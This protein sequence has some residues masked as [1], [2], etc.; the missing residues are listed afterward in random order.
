M[1]FCMNCDNEATHKYSNENG[2]FPLCFTCKE[3][4]GLGQ[5]NQDAEIKMINE[6][7]ED[8]DDSN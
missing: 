1:I 2:T 5:V 6:E 7:T 3:A 4:F 8:D